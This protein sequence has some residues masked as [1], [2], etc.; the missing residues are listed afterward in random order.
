MY[1]NLLNG[2]ILCS[3]LILIGSLFHIFIQF[4][5]RL[6]EDLQAKKCEIKMLLL[7]DCRVL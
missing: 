4:T 1:N 2:L 5:I 6:L 3:V 7:L